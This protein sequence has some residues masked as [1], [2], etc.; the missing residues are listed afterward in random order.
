MRNGNE[1]L[2]QRRI[3]VGEV[4]ADLPG[5]SVLLAA[6]AVEARAESL[7]RSTTAEVNRLNSNLADAQQRHEI[8]RQR[9]ADMSRQIEELQA[10]HR[11][12]QVGPGQPRHRQGDTGMAVREGLL[13]QAGRP[14]F[15]ISLGRV[16]GR[17]WWCLAAQ[18]RPGVHHAGSP[19]A[20]RHG[21]ALEV[22][23]SPARALRLTLMWLKWWQAVPW[24]TSHCGMNCCS[25]CWPWPT[26]PSRHPS[27]HAAGPAPGHGASRWPRGCRLGWWRRRWPPA[28]RQ[29]SDGSRRASAWCSPQRRTHDGGSGGVPA[30]GEAVRQWP[31]GCDRARRGGPACGD[32]ELRGGDGPE[33]LRQEHT[34]APGSGAG[35]PDGRVRSSGRREPPARQGGGG[36]GAVR[37]DTV[38]WCCAQLSSPRSPPRRTWPSR[39]S[40]TGCGRR[41]RVPPLRT[42]WH[43]PGPLDRYPAGGQQQRIRRRAHRGRAGHPLDDIVELFASLPARPGTVLATHDLRLAKAS[44]RL[45]RDG[46]VVDDTARLE[47]TA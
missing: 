26:A 28:R 7:V 14:C 19:G 37:R 44:G 9:H 5:G 1:V 33:R 2:V 36:G 41:W 12:L 25:R 17:H 40:W 20:G 16:R 6:M 21:A 15:A 11:F 10:E 3:S 24:S 38:V 18:R 13:A 32:G 42:R 45:L 39:W 22:A 47:A 34:P 23:E 35:R 43:G 29:I 30:G 27:A 46:V 31:D 8:L 4:D